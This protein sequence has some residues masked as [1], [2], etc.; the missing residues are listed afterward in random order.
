MDDNKADLTLW[1]DAIAQE[2]DD[3]INE[4]IERGYRLTRDKSLGSSSDAKLED[5]RVEIRVIDG[6]PYVQ[7]TVRA[8]GDV[9]GTRHQSPNGDLCLYASRDR[10]NQ[11]WR[12]ADS[13]LA[14]VDLWFEKN[15]QGWPDDPPALDIEAYLDLPI[16]T[17]YVMYDDLSTLSDDYIEIRADQRTLRVIGP[18]KVPK[19]STKG[20]LSGYVTDL[21]RT[22]HAATELAR[23]DHERRR[24]GA[25]PVRHRT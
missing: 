11:P 3:F 10:D 6:F 14:R 22:H 8:I 9:P 21:G 20:I 5:G 23:P 18:G 25:H 1:N 16:D 7:P 2:R 17:G 4:L 24:A 15:E 19:K 13:L 12:D